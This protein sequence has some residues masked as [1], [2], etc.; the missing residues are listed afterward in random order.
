VLPGHGP[1]TTLGHE[2]TTND[3]VAMYRRS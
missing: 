2:L 1:T 3:Y